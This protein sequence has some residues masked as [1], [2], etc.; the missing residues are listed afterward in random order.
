MT[1]TIQ[2]LVLLLAVVAAVAIVANRLRIPPSIPLVVTGVLLALVPGLPPVELAPEIVLLL[3]LPPII[4]TSAFQ[5]SWR[6]FRFNLRP[7]GLLSVGGVVFTTLAVAV[8]AHWLMDLPWSVGFELGAIISPPDAI[9]PLSIAR[10]MEIPR[11]ILVVLEGEALANDATALILYRFAVAAVSL[12][13]FSF[14]EAAGTFAAIF[15]G[16]ILWGIG[17]GWVMLRLRR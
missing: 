17:V 16:E 1:S 11:R 15:V 2:I 13:V 12:G 10:R 14:G 5:M 7:I 3:V 8:A 9:A 6:E 4:Y